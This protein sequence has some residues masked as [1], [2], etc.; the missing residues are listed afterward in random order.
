MD[1]AELLSVDSLTSV[2]KRKKECV[3]SVRGGGGD[4]EQNDEQT[5]VSGQGDFDT[6]SASQSKQRSNTQKLTRQLP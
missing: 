6:V 5:D 1:S 3:V 4:K 2:L